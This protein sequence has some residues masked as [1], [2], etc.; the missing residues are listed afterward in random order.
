MWVQRTSDV[1]EIKNR[2]TKN[3]I[4]SHFWFSQPLLIS[5]KSL[6]KRAWTK[7]F[8][9]SLLKISQYSTMWKFYASELISGKTFDQNFIS[10]KFSCIKSC[11]EIFQSEIQWYSVFGKL[12]SGV[13]DRKYRKNDTI[14]KLLIYSKSLFNN[15]NFILT[16]QWIFKPFRKTFWAWARGFPGN[17]FQNLGF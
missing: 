8:E 17:F 2:V 4:Q 5:C 11:P 10:G 15:L 16:F 6:W 13:F 1:R 14:V 9:N 12:F 3:G 7:I